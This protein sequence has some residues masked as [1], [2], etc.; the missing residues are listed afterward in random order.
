MFNLQLPQNSTSFGNV[1]YGILRELYSR[2]ADDFLLFDIGMPDLTVFNKIRED[3]EY[4]DWLNSKRRDVLAKF[5]KYDAGIKLWHINSS[6]TS[7]SNH[8]WLFT[9]HE[10]D[11]ITGV[12]KNILNN[13]FGIF[14]SSEYTKQVFLDGGVTVPIVVLPL[15]FDS[16][17]FKETGKQYHAK[18]ITHWSIYGKF[19]HRKRHE[20][21]IRAWV[22][23]FGGNYSH[24]LNLNIYNPFLKPEHNNAILAQIFEGKPKPFNVNILPYANTLSELNE[25]YNNTDIVIDMSGAEGFSLPSF[26]CACLGKHVVAHNNTGIKEWAT[27]EN[28]V[29]VEPSSKIS[30]KDGMF[31]SGEGD[32]NIGNIYDYEESDLIDAFDK[33]LVRKSVSQVN[34]AGLE[35]KEGF[36]WKNCVDKILKTVKIEG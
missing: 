15:G 24:V 34:Y 36:S 21:T 8:Q 7:I 35:L 32:F 3:S 14:V 1:S 27:S 20:K 6:E 19:E 2:K 4:I 26:T 33:I 17:H 18:D 9:F 12:E 16:E 10:L 5:S 31:F 30:A 25:S 28:S 22:K 29:L 23:K 13:Q 11:E